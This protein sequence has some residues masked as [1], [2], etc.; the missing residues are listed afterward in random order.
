[1]QQDLIWLIVSEVN[2]L[3]YVG[4]LKVTCNICWSILNT[5]NDHDRVAIQKSTNLIHNSTK[6]NHEVPFSLRIN[7]ARCTSRFFNTARGF[8]LTR[9]SLSS[10]IVWTTSM[11]VIYEELSICGRYRL[12]NIAI[13]E[14]FLNLQANDP[15]G[16]TGHNFPDLCLFGIIS[17]HFLALQFPYV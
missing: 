4:Y 7:L 16:A 2:K 6:K 1:M 14:T 13:K 17:P 3:P 15:Y 11:T 10:I 5:A 8:D 12:W 9:P